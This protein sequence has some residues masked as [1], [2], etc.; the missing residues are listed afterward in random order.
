VQLLEHEAKDL[1]AAAGLTVPDGSLAETPEQAQAIARRLGGRVIVKAQIPA[2]ARAAGG[3][4]R[5]A[6]P[7]EA[8]STAA[9][10]LGSTVHGFLVTTVLVERHV[11][12]E[13]A[14]YAGITVDPRA[15]AAVL[16]VSPAGGAGV[17]EHAEE[18][19]RAIVPALTGLR[20]WHLRQ[21]AN[22]AGLEPG[23]AAVVLPA[24]RALY[25]VFR[26]Q[27]ARLVEANPLL[28]SGEGTP[29]TAADVRVVPAAA[30]AEGDYLV[31]D[32]E[33]D[34][35]LLTTGAGGSMLL[36][37]LLR[38]AGL[39][40]IDFCDARTG[41]LRGDPQ[42]LVD[43]LQRLDRH[44][45]M[46]CLGV[47]VFAGI[48]KLDEFADLLLQALERVR[49]GVPIVV[50]IEGERGEAARARLTAAGLACARDLDLVER[51]AA[52]ARTG[53]P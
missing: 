1:A 8:G 29:P 26:E 6:E 35:G 28:L 41:G 38:D 32:A 37:D 22:G 39:R 16:V 34:V 51:L 30:H 48:T 19:G 50:R 2:A 3:G 44:P 5:E 53:G 15:R 49:P 23:D 43:I 11:P 45:T 9:R 17:E 18:A 25:R 20:D 21:A 40:P 36:V 46:R 52:A 33:G 7:D 4:I 13:R 14:L 31:L 27:R 24:A 47:N 10:L 12:A 42:R